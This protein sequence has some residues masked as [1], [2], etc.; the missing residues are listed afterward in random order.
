M[1]SPPEPPVA[2]VSADEQMRI[3]EAVERGEMDVTE[4]SRRLSGRSIDA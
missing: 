3:L 1:P 4:A 2:P